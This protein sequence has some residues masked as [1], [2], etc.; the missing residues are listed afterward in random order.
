[1]SNGSK[2]SVDAP[3]NRLLR[4]S[5][6]SDSCSDSK[7][8]YS[9]R[10]ACTESAV[11]LL[12]VAALKFQLE[13]IAQSRKR[14]LACVRSRSMERSGIA[15]EYRSAWRRGAFKNAIRVPSDKRA[16]RAASSRRQAWSRISATRGLARN[17]NSEALTSAALSISRL[18][19]ASA[20]SRSIPLEIANPGFMRSLHSDRMCSL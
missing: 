16:S 2:V 17:S 20:S 11:A 19:R 15:E 14:F 1:M 8:T 4:T 7:K 6:N 3:S 9:V 5:T 13:S 18:S 10:N 12:S